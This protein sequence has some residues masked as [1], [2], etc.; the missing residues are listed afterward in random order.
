VRVQVAGE[1]F[2]LSM[3]LSL[4]NEHDFVT[5]QTFTGQQ[6]VSVYLLLC[7]ALCEANHALHCKI[8]LTVIKFVVTSGPLKT[9][10]TELALL[11]VL[12]FY[13]KFFGVPCCLIATKVLL[14]EMIVVQIQHHRFD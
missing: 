13:S 9:F 12:K 7:V 2:Q 5:M 4:L 8:G 10:S 6:A 1:F 11:Q 3:V 14:A